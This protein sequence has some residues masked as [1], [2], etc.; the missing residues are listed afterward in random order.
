MK[1]KLKVLDIVIICCSVIMI[2]PTALAYLATRWFV[3]PETKTDFTDV[4]IAE[5]CAKFKFDP[6]PDEAVSAVI[7]ANGLLQGTEY[8]QILIDNVTSEEDLLSRFQGEY[9]KTEKYMGG[10]PMKNPVS[11]YELE[12]FQLDKKPKDYHCQLY[13]GRE[14]GKTRALFWVIGYIPELDD[15]YDFS[16]DN[17]Q[18]IV[19]AGV[20]WVPLGIEIFLIVFLMGRIFL[21]GDH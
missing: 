15:I 7:N 17:A 20:F 6:A 10:A 3:I 13:F 16:Q 12:I 14:G 11:A 8:V 5:I 1:K 2:L 4:Q 21:R 9:K 19:P 18:S